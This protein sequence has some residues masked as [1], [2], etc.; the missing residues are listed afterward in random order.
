MFEYTEYEND[1]PDLLCYIACLFHN[2]QPYIKA[3]DAWYIGVTC[4][5]TKAERDDSLLSGFVGGETI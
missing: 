1:H 5:E 2:G 3:I 4:I